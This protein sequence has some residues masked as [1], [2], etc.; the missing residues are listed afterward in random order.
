MKMGKVRDGLRENEGGE[1]GVEEGQKERDDEGERKWGR[2]GMRR[3]EG[4]ITK[5]WHRN[6]EG[7]E[8][9]GYRKERIKEEG[10]GIVKYEREVV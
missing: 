2:K 9:D 1:R 4:G 6:K 3:G 8:R 10:E 5:R 7:M